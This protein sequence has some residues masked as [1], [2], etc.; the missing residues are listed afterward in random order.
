MINRITQEQRIELYDAFDSG[1]YEKANRLLKEYAGIEAKPYTAYMFY[2]ES[3]N[4][5]GDSEINDVDDILRA[6]YVE[7]ENN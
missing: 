7:V 2:D 6:A 5:V 4:Y 1:D 3:G